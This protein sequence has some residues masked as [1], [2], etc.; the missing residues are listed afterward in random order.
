MDYMIFA[1][2]CLRSQQ[3]EDGAD[4]IPSND[5]DFPLSEAVTCLRCDSL[6]SQQLSAGGTA[7]SLMC[8]ESLVFLSNRNAENFLP[9]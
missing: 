7:V 8:H 3:T 9:S 6:L 2:K 4:Y 1:G 5:L